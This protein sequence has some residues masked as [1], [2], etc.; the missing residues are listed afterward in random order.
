MRGVGKIGDFQPITRRI[1]ITVEDG[2][3]V[4]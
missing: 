3:K 1:S 2:V 4:T